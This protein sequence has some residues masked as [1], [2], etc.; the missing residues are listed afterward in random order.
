MAASA[1]FVSTISDDLLYGSNDELFISSS[2]STLHFP[3]WFN[4]PDFQ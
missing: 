3:L 1:N 2:T 4:T